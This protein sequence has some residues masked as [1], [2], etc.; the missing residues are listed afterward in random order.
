MRIKSRANRALHRFWVQFTLTPFGCLLRLFTGRMFHGGELG[1]G[2]LDAGMGTVL[3]LMAMPGLFV[4]LLTFEK[5]GHLILWLRGGRPF[6]PFKATLPDEYFF[7]VLSLVVSAGAALW[8][9]DSIFLDRRDYTNVVPLPVKLSSI[10]LANLCAILFVTAL[11]TTVAN[12]ASVVLF[13]I[14]VVGSQSSLSVFLR[15]AGGHFISVLTASVFGCFAVFGLTG[16]LMA[17]LPTPTFRRIS[18]LARFLMAIVLLGLLTSSFVV[19][20]LL[21]EIAIPIAQHLALLPPFSFLGLTR[22]MWGS[23]GEPFVPEMARSAIIALAVGF[24]VTLLAYAASF[25][26]IFLR[27]PETSESGPFPRSQFGTAPLGWLNKVVLRGRPQQACYQFVAR[28]L[29]RSE[30]HLQIFLGF[31][32]LG[33]VLSANE[34]S[35]AADLH[36]I[37]AGK[38]PSIDVLSVPFVLSFC[39]IAGLRLAFEIPAELRANW[40]FRF[41]LDRDQHSARAI[42]RHALLVFALPFL[43]PLCFV[44]TLVFWGWAIA[45]LHTAIVALS[46]VVLAEVSLL[47]FRKLPFTC[48]YPPFKSHSGL[49]VVAY[50]FAY[51]FYTGYLARIER[52]SLFD[53][54][55]T[56]CFIPP[57]AAVLV[58]AYYYRNQMLDLDKQLLFEEA[59]SSTYL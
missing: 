33:L 39:I 4:S 55:R 24:I 38:V 8:L 5:Y 53:P 52:W 14:A 23:G 42:A 31:L 12:A 56:I 17:L 29:L 50:L 25:R 7:I 48:T 49:V 45:A 28:T 41:W 9:W 15:F 32:A 58:G 36:G 3:I 59:G 47:R 57:V 18:H 20:E 51:L 34:L 1:S 30:R 19:P 16:L 46:T 6:D 35:S 11:F 21:S 43:L 2:E 54:W 22:T 40:V 44:L 27:I 26:R 10:F 13:P 37:I